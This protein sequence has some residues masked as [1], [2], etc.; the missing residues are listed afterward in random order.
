MEW[1]ISIEDTDA[2][3]NT[4]KH[5]QSAPGKRRA[6]TRHPKRRPPPPARPSRGFCN[7]IGSVEE[8]R[9]EQARKYIER[10]KGWRPQRRTVI[11]LAV[12]GLALA[13]SALFIPR[14]LPGKLHN[15]EVVIG[16]NEAVTVVPMGGGAAARDLVEEPRLGEGY[17]A[18]AISDSREEVAVAWYSGTPRKVERAT[19]QVRSAFSGRNQTEWSYSAEDGPALIEQVGYIPQQN[20]IWFLA[21]GRL[22]M[23]DIKSGRVLPLPFKGAEA[24]GSLPEPAEVTY[25]TFAPSG[26]LLAYVEGGALMVVRGLGIA[27]GQGKL[28]SSV[29]LRSGGTA[30]GGVGVERGAIERLTWLDE[31]R[32]AVVAGWGADAE[33]PAQDVYLLAVDARGAARARRLLT[34]EGQRVMSISRAPRGTDFALLVDTSPRLTTGEAGRYQVL[35]YSA[36]GRLLRRTRLPRGSWEGPLSWTSP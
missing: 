32:M 24:R 22:V 23:I 21:G 9:V 11:Y 33:S 10:G 30:D 3:G 28:S 6:S 36:G 34:I 18:W 16:R 5:A 17:S 35:Q 7:I 20:L 12:M 4:G 14:L 19:V 1:A 8:N 31:S 26:G 15:S 25:A 27:R 29:V 2:E 13:F